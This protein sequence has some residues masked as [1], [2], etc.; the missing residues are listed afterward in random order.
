MANKKTT[1]KEV[2]KSNIKK[3]KKV[4][5]DINE[6]TPYKNKDGEQKM[7]LNAEQKARK[8]CVELH[9]GK[10]VYNDKPLSK[11]QKAYRSGWLAKRTQNASLHNYAIKQ[12][13]SKKN[14]ELF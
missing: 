13:E 4:Q 1:T 8:Y 5:F 10:D 3:G 12:E 11:S 14:D 6:G 7:Y 9:T 2:E